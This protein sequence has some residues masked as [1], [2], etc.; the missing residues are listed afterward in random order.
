MCFESKHTLVM[1]VMEIVV[2]TG[3]N[4][5]LTHLRNLQALSKETGRQFLEKPIRKLD[6]GNNIDTRASSETPIHRI[7]NISVI[8]SATHAPAVED[9]VDRHTSTGYGR[10]IK[11]N[12]STARPGT[13]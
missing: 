8:G 10:Y 9:P 4:Q 12:L 2:K 5:P 1:V 11:P 3:H 6:L 13:V 7:I